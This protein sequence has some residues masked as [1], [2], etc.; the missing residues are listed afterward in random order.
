MAR[1]GNV[2]AEAGLQRFEGVC[3]C[4]S[5]ARRPSCCR[6]GGP[7]CGRPGGRAPSRIARRSRHTMWPWGGK[8]GQGPAL[9]RLGEELPGGPG[10]EQGP[11]GRLREGAL[12]FANIGAWD[13]DGRQP[14]R[15]RTRRK[16]RCV[17]ARRGDRKGRRQ[18]WQ[19]GCLAMQVGGGSFREGGQAAGQ[20]GDWRGQGGE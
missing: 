2:S 13:G 5:R 19:R 12:G 15:G 3:P 9:D 1:G 8:A 7:P 18:R 17:D 4:T 20:G 6:P 11:G 16:R 14:R 10:D